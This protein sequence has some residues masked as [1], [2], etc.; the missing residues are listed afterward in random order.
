MHIERPEKYGGPV[1]YATDED[2]CEAYFSSSLS[3]M[4]LKSGVTDGLA[5]TLRP[6]RE[7]FDAK[8]ENYQAL[9]KVLEGIKKLR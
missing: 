6:A 2:L 4:D 1:D 5:E 8:P 7:Y 3:P 9:L